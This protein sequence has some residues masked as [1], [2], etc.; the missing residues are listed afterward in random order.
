MPQE[1]ISS[2]RVRLDETQARL[3]NLKQSIAL[4]D[5]QRKELQDLMKQTDA[6][7]SNDDVAV[8]SAGAME[9][10]SAY[11]EDAEWRRLD[12]DVRTRRHGI[13]KQ[14]QDRPRN[15]HGTPTTVT[16]ATGFTYEEQMV[17]LDRQL[18]QSKK[19]KELL[20]AE[21]KDQNKAFEELFTSAQTLIKENNALA[22]KREL[23]SA[24]RQRLDQKNME[25]NV[26]GSIDVLSRAFVPS[27]PDKDRRVVFTAMALCMSLGLSGGLAFLRSI[28]NQVIYAAKDMPHQMQ[29]PLLGHIP[30][31]STK[32]PPEEEVSLAM[33][34]SVRVVR[35]ALLS[36]LNGQ[37]C[38]TVLVTSAAAGTGK[39]S[40]TMMLGKSLAR[41]GKKIL[42]VDADF[43]KMTLSK[44]LNLADKS[45]FMES[46]RSKSVDKRHI[47]PTSTSGLSVMP[48]GAHDG[49]DLVFEEIA[50][51][52]FKACVSQLR[53]QYNIILFDSSPILPVAD[54]A[55][56]SSQVDGTIMVER[57][58]VSQRSNVVNALTRLSSAGGRLLG[59]VFIGSRSHEYH[60]YDY[61]YSYGYSTAS[62][63]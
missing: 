40:F 24:V 25:R 56:L 43:R 22:H 5:W 48:A 49:D 29:S 3:S 23:F 41:A 57:E 61:N 20:D 35:T 26:P 21:L 52:A 31:T 9:D 51:G 30:A 60:G 50:N 15:L 6:E 14:W 11:Y 59:T 44:R 12:I 19:E 58:L 27:T 45:G 32:R 16:A 39:S 46:L 54:A 1:L 34:E 47:F 18:D 17:F 4:L 7:D 37:D 55:I 53:K 8:A 13:D 42:L 28:K 2:R 33:I 36:R 10:K 63:S 62:E 38:T